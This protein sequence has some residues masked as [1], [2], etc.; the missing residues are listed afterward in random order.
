MADAEI[1]LQVD[2]DEKGAV[3]KAGTI[4]KKFAN[5]GKM[6]GSAV[7]TGAT[8][9]GTALIGLVGKSVQMAGELEQQIGGT[10]AVFGDFASQVQEQANKSY[11]TMGTS[12]NQ[13]MATINKMGALMQGSGIDQQK[14]MDLS[15]AAMQRTADVA[16][17]MGIDIEMA[18]ES[19]AGAAKGNFMMMDNL[20]V[21][22]NATSIEAY[23]LSKGVD[24]S[25]NS[26]TKA[27]QVGYA[28][29]MFLEK[30]AYATGNYTKENETFAGSLQ[31]LK[32]SFS[33][34]MAGTGDISAVIDSVVSFGTILVEKIIEMAPKVINGIVELFNAII[35]LLPQ[36][37]QQL[38]PPV[39]NGLFA[40]MNALIPMIP[41]I[42][43]IVVDMIPMIVTGLLEMLPT[44]LQAGITL[45]VALIQ[46]MAEL[47]PTMI[48][49]IIDAIIKLVPLLIKKLPLFVNAGLKLII[50]LLSGIIQALPRIWA[51]LPNIISKIIG[52][53]AQL[54]GQMIKYGKNLVSGLWSGISNSFSWIKNKIKGW[55]GDVMSFIKKLFGIA[56]PSKEFAIIGRYNVEGLAEGMADMEGDLEKQM[57]K[58]FG[59]SLDY[60]ANLIPSASNMSNAIYVINDISIEQD[61]LGQMVNKIKSYAGGSKLDYIGG[62]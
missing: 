18:M 47:L 30:T 16:S 35:P 9:A 8:V 5:A 15:A 51:E 1:S 57:D 24:K 41:Q 6:I 53:F 38:L 60:V 36:L 55:I 12:A 56:S 26:M 58:T 43:Q 17:I 42:V 40:L 14:S 46:G 29:E 50:G 37:M 7:L 3:N 27:E 2:V 49:Q 59:G 25:F 34:F 19:V 45:I 48:P 11:S 21:A 61:P 10:E 23:A 31:T 33:N 52:Y 4:G 22:M 39:I 62:N 20:G 32:A 28:M 13:Y 44:L 54:P